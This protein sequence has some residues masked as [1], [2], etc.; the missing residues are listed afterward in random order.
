MTV[1]GRGERDEL[2]D[3]APVERTMMIKAP[4]RPPPP[5]AAP[6]T[7]PLMPA[8]RAWR[9]YQFSKLEKVSKVHARLLKN[10]EWMLPN[11]RATGEVSESV[12]KRL[13]EMFEE[14]V[15]LRVE[16]AQVVPASRLRQFVGDPTFLAVLAPAPQKTRG[17]LE[18]ELGLANMA[19]DLLM[20]GAGEA[21]ALRPLTDLE[22]GVITYV[23]LE[24][25]KALSPSLDP[26]LPKLRIESVVRSFEDALSTVG[27]D[28]H[29]AVVQ[30][31]AVF[32]TYPGYVRLF[33]PESVL[34]G[35]SPPS[36]AEVRRARRLSDVTQNASRV[37]NVKAWLRAEIAQVDIAS[38][39]LAQLRERDVI[40]VD[41]LTAR[42]DK[43]EGG[44]A[45]LRVGHGRLGLMNAEVVAEEGRYKAKITGF[46][47]GEPAPP[48]G[49]TEEEGVQDPPAE[50]EAPPEG[51]EGGDVEEST[52][53]GNK[54][55]D[56]VEGNAEG[57]ELL[58]DIPMQISVEIGRVPITAEEVVG[59][60]VGHVIDL[61]RAPGEPLDLSVNGRIVAR[62]ELVEV[63]GN[64]GIRI[65][66]L[67]G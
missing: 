8:A 21:V 65:L 39:D 7:Q 3:D 55:R 24:T 12:K 63:E 26:T 66:S 50:G 27:E 44:T 57:G 10:L 5:A 52:N 49:P 2:G 38:G 64:L 43:G 31:Q 25:L 36:D 35:V 18:V 48:G 41:G 42:P 34:V 29:L 60:K 58:N 32:G 23:L 28:E 16:S 45:K 40:L 54:G 4:T 67:A 17:L 59:L 20:G 37:R 51:E 9:R 13:S 19:I 61:N 14:K 1:R 62:G 56:Q 47:I 6:P 53:P 22:E 11:V 15:T 30:L 46:Q 33:I